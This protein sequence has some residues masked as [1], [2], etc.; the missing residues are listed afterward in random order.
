MNTKLFATLAGMTL[1]LVTSAHAQPL[2]EPFVDNFDMLRQ[3]RWQISNGW[4]N[5]EGFACAWRA[6]NAVG[7]AG[8]LTLSI[9]QIPT[10]GKPYACAE[11]QSRRRY[12]FGTYEFK[13]APALGSG[14]TTTFF[15]MARDENKPLALITVNILGNDPAHAV[16]YVGTAA[17]ASRVVELPEALRGTEIPMAIN[18]RKDA[19]EFFVN[20]EMVSKLTSSDAS[21]PQEPMNVLMSTFNKSDGSYGPVESTP[22]P[23][24]ARFQ[25]VSFTPV[26][27]ACQFP[28]SV[29]CRIAS[30]N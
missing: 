28:A 12:G 10:G 27:S 30:S 3:S 5:G 24:R 4:S 17:S 29:V 18:W 11:I 21:I 2:S 14:I 1:S 19:V 6:L 22:M 15:L 25:Q 13:V 9:E 20:G 23:A 16:F 26:G 8:S 7:D